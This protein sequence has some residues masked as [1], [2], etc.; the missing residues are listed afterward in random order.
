M[1]DKETITVLVDTKKNLDRVSHSIEIYLCM[2]NNDHRAGIIYLTYKFYSDTG[3]G[4]SSGV[5]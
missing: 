2:Y 3:A 1:A 5:L 4:V